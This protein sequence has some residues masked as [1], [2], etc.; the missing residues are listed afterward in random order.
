MH[1]LSVEWVAFANI[2]KPI[3]FHNIIVILELFFIKMLSI[4]KL[5]PQIH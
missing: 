5:F 4:K 3:Y 2:E 1:A